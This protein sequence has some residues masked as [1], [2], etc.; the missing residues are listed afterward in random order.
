MEIPNPTPITDPEKEITAVDEI[1]KLK[2]Y[3]C[4]NYLGC[5]AVAAKENWLQFTCEACP[6][7]I[8]APPAPEDIGILQTLGKAL[9][10]N[11]D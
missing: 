4:R 11:I 1:L 5:L 10:E 2:R 7:Y 8:Y 9:A 6:A 3:D